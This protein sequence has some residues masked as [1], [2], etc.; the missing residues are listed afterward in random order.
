MREIPYTKTKCILQDKYNATQEEIVL[1]IETKKIIPKDAWVITNVGSREKKLYRWDGLSSYEPNDLIFTLESLYFNEDG[2]NKFVPKDRWISIKQIVERWKKHGENSSSVAAKLQQHLSVPSIKKSIENGENIDM[3]QYPLEGIEETKAET[4]FETAFDFY[5]NYQEPSKDWLKWLEKLGLSINDAKTIA[6]PRVPDDA[7]AS[8]KLLYEAE[9]AALDL[10]AQKHDADV[11]SIL[12]EDINEPTCHDDRVMLCV[13]RCILKAS[14]FRNP[15]TEYQEKRNQK[16]QAKIAEINKLLG[17]KTIT[18]PQAQTMGNVGAGSKLT[19]GL[20][21]VK[22]GVTSTIQRKKLKPL[23]RETN[24]GLLLLYEIFIHYQV[25]YLDELR[26]NN[27]WGKV[28][29]GEF[30]SELIVSVSDGKRSIT[31]SGGEKLLKSNFLE[32]Y[33]KRFKIN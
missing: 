32:K 6:N 18:E 26:A 15:E 10:K 23:K 5:V 29:S 27:A 12:S 20:L 24:T 25:N 3:Y 2:I 31:L 30:N 28:V 1:W 33:R 9:L 4:E 7:P 17:Q 13:W 14:K 11:D 8:E 16:F 19:A 21:N 22:D